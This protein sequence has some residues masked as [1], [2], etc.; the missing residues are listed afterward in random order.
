MAITATFGMLNSHTGTGGEL[1]YQ[2]ASDAIAD[3]RADSYWAT[4][5]DARTDLQE[6]DKFTISRAR[7]AAE[8]FVAKNSVNPQT[9]GVRG[10]V[11][12]ANATVK[13]IHGRFLLAPSGRLLWRSDPAANT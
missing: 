6:H 2:H 8:D 11:S 10:S 5:I 3:I 12:T 7:E 13:S 1:H 9:L 4:D